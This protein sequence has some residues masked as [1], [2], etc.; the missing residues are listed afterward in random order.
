MLI[1]NGAGLAATAA[2]VA[3]S[4][5]DIQLAEP[6][7]PTLDLPPLQQQILAALSF[8]PMALETLALAVAQPLDQLLV[9]LL[10][11][12]LEKRVE[13]IGGCYVRL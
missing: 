13:T 12:E 1:A 2:D 7:Q 9:V 3:F 10:E 6:I 8:E 4:F 11:L 5:A